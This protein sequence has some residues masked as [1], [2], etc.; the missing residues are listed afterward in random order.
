[1]EQV[2]EING[3]KMRIRIGGGRDAA[4]IGQLLIFDKEYDPMQTA[5]F[6]RVLKLGMNVVD[7]GAN[8]GY[9]TL[10]AA[11]LVGKTGRVWAVEPEPMNI[12]DL[13]WNRALNGF[14]NIE[15]AP[16]AMGHKD[17][18]VKLY[19]SPVSSGRH[20]ATVLRSDG[21]K[22]ITVS[23]ERLDSLIPPKTK[24][25]LVKTDTEGGDM[26]VMRGAGRVI[27]ENPDIVWTMEVW[28]TGLKKIG[29]NVD[30][31]FGLA[32]ENGF[33]RATMLDEKG[34]REVEISYMLPD[35]VKEY[36]RW[37][38]GCNVVFRK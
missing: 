28:P 6:K 35:A 9:Y 2:V 16:E 8:I 26:D 17:G 33:R 1:M 31:L 27:R 34:K 23:M 7:V 14:S 29:E 25:D 18:T 3:Y 24:I 12:G 30:S 13:A 15:I 21:G 5:M 36:C 11:S 4:G 38:N 20:S 19:V 32:I 22:S 37:H 10:L